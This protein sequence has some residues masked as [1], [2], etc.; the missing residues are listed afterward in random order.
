MP[1]SHSAIVA[2]IT[3][4]VGIN[5]G[6]GSDIFILS[7][8]FYLV[9]VRDAL[10]VRRA[11]GLQAKKL[12]EVGKMLEKKGLYNEFKKIKEVNGHTPMEVV[13]GSLLGLFNGIAFAVL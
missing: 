3:T 4:S 6:L 5:S 9:T 2:C 8:C 13:V 1:S 10:G 7:L 11:N 12:N